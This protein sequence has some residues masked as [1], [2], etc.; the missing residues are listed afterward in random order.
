[1]TKLI[2]AMIVSACRV[3]LWR[4][5]SENYNNAMSV[6]YDDGLIRGSDE[7]DCPLSIGK[8][9]ELYGLTD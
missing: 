1:M 6:V 9:N 2:E 3:L 5:W 7:N 4:G 8:M